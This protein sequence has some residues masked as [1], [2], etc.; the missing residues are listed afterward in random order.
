MGLRIGGINSNMEIRRSLSSRF[1]RHSS[2]SLHFSRYCATAL[3]PPSPAY[4]SGANQVNAYF[5]HIFSSMANRIKAVLKL[6]FAGS[7]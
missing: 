1:P 5:N 3:P 4:G 6:P 7:I 2:I